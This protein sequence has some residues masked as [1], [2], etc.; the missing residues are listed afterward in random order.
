MKHV[1]RNEQ[2]IGRDGTRTRTVWRRRI[3]SETPDEIELGEVQRAVIVADKP[4]KANFETTGGLL[5][6]PCKITRKR[7]MAC[8][9]SEKPPKEIQK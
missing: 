9:Y 2:H 4:C 7:Y 6:R 3:I 1:Y 5:S 8:G